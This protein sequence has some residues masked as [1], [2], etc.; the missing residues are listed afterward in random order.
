VSGSDI[1]VISS[2]SPA[3]ARHQANSAAA[4]RADSDAAAAGRRRSQSAPPTPPKGTQ[5]NLKLTPLQWH[6]LCNSDNN[7]G[8]SASDVAP[9]RP[10]PANVSAAPPAPSVEQWL[11]NAR[12]NHERDQLLDAA[13][14]GGWWPSAAPTPSWRAP[15]AQRPQPQSA[16]GD[17]SH[18]IL[19]HGRAPTSLSTA[20]LYAHDDATNTLSNEQEDLEALEAGPS[21]PLLRTELLSP[22]RSE[23]AP[24]SVR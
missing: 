17:C 24:S 11:A 3:R 21:L 6:T 4:S 7:A 15:P 14:G 16:E 10:A 18:P 22:R 2:L 8:T 9:A 19:A 20:F 13:R 23:R 1:S 12:A 5:G